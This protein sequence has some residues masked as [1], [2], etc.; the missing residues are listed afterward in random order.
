M[1]VAEL[2]VQIGIKG[3]GNANKALSNV[4]E[5][6]QGII[7][8]SLAAKAAIAAV[9]YGL[10][11]LTEAAGER[12]AGLTQFATLTN[13]DTSKLQVLENILRQVG[14]SKEDV[15]GT[16]KAIQAVTTSIQMHKGAPAE[17]V[18][19]M[20]AVQMD[21]KR[22]GD[23]LYVLQKMGEYSKT[24]APNIAKAMLG[25]IGVGSDS[26]L[27]SLIRNKK[28]LESLSGGNILSPNQ[29]KQLTEVNRLWDNFKYNIE[30]AFN[31]FTSDHGK[32]IIRDVTEITNAIITLTSRLADLG[33]KFEVFDRFSKMLQGISNLFKIDEII[34]KESKS[35][36]LPGFKNSPVG[37]LSEQAA[38][39]VSGFMKFLMGAG[40]QDDIGKRMIKDRSMLPP[41]VTPPNIQ[42]P[43]NNNVSPTINIHT[44][45]ND[46]EH[47]ASVISREIKR[48]VFQSNA[49]TQV[50]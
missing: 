39:E 25:S 46:P 1:K 21:P 35:E 10:Q 37:K 23:T 49:I 8:S 12:G 42:Q 16:L 31:K 20:A 30:T 44:E 33:E 19:M 27:A 7:S 32:N 5:G 3:A 11:R 22:I 41:V 28:D 15:E 38:G 26:M 13:I 36:G 40:A 50:T 17:F 47:H 18:R 2:F 34:K 24:V 6:M 29:I 14:A 48:A 43:V 9:L 4:N 45:T